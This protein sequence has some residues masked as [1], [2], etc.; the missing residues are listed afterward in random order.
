MRWSIAAAHSSHGQRSVLS[1]L[2]LL[3]QC[4]D[5][6]PPTPAAH[7]RLPIVTIRILRGAPTCTKHS[8]SHIRQCVLYSLRPRATFLQVCHARAFSN[9]FEMFTAQMHLA[10]STCCTGG[11]SHYGVLHDCC[12]LVLLSWI[13]DM[14]P[15][16][17]ACACG[18]SGCLL[19][20]ELAMSAGADA[21]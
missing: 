10:C 15:L 7:Q 6:M 21:C 11:K 16:L 20:Q 17:H 18:L 9:L 14:F 4:N 13:S 19:T 12:M 8:Q 5:I 2:Q 3:G 1:C